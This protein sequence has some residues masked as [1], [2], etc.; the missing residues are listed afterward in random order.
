MVQGVWEH[1]RYVFCGLS[2]GCLQQQDTAVEEPGCPLDSAGPYSGG[3]DSITLLQWV[4]PEHLQRWV[5]TT[6]EPGKQSRHIPFSS[7]PDDRATCTLRS[8]VKP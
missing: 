3:E 2:Q 5:E 8:M 6:Q 7:T 4:S 1:P